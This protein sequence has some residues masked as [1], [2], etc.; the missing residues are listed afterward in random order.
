MKCLESLYNA[1]HMSEV[2]EKAEKMLTEVSRFLFSSEVRRYSVKD[3]SARRYPSSVFSCYL[4][5]LQYGLARDKAEEAK[6]ALELVNASICE[7]V[8]MAAASEVA[9]NDV[10]AT[11]HQVANRFLSLCLEEPWVRR[12]AGCGGIKVMTAIPDLGVRWV[13]E[14]EVDL[15][16]MLLHVLKDMPHD[17]SHD[18]DSVVDVLHRVLRVS[19]VDPPANESE[20]IRENKIS[21]VAGLFF[22][23]L[24]SPNPIVR[25]AAQGCISLLAELSGKA[26]VDLLM[27]H[28]DR[29]LASIYTKPLRALPFP[30]QI[31]IDRK[32]VV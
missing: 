4:D 20:Q 7:L 10:F 27:P 8:T 3:S 28:R 23:E 5:A 16:R 25:Q 18:A 30:L 15:V 2:Q 21:H 11:L 19:T 24:S 31:G 26:I 22:A 14:R 1:I 29:M 12:S 13:N 6:R 17:M 9:I 32:S